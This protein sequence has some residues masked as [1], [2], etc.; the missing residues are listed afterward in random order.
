MKNLDKFVQYCRQQCKILESVSDE[1]FLKGEFE[2]I[3]PPFGATVAT[4]V[5]DMTLSAKDIDK[6]RTPVA[7]VK[8]V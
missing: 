6:A 2:F 4:P 5:P 7:H 3:T 1:D 8:G